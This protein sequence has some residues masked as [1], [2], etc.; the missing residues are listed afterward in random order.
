LTNDDGP[1]FII[2]PL[3]DESWEF[4]VKDDTGRRV[5]ALTAMLSPSGLPKVRTVWLGRQSSWSVQLQL[6]F[7]QAGV[8]QIGVHYPGTEVQEY[9]SRSTAVPDGTFQEKRTSNWLRIEVRPGG[10]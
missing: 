2:V 10:K 1:R 6:K 3:Q 5:R 9:L 4:E 7:T 8:F